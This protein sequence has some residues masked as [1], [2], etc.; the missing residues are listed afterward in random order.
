MITRTLFM[1]A[2][3]SI[4]SYS[5]PDTAEHHSEIVIRPGEYLVKAEILMPH[6]EANLRYA[7]TETRHCL[8]RDNVSSLFPLLAHVSF[9]GC[10]LVE[11]QSAGEYK[12]FDLV[13]LNPEAA[14]GS[15]QLVADEEVLRAT[16]NVKMGAKNMKFSQ[17]INGH[18]IGDCN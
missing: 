1:V 10:S 2:A 8:N 12:E 3:L 15:A 13:C 17:R 18:R 9:T 4:C 16:L 14:T 7:T 6:L 11:K 5:L